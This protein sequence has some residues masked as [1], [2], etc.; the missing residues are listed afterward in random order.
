MEFSNPI[1]TSK[2]GIA[3][4]AFV[5]GTVNLSKRLAVFDRENTISLYTDDRRLK[6]LM[7]ELK[8]ATLMGLDVITEDWLWEE[9]RRERGYLHCVLKGRR[10]L[11]VYFRMKAGRTVL[12]DAW[13]REVVVLV[14][15]IDSV[16]K[17]E[18]F[19]FLTYAVEGGGDLSEF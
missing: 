8:I 18:N 19:L 17:A 9:Y 1:G 13:L 3:L 5:D 7:K 4:T 6:A 11:E 16:I 2:N 15:V 12:Q 10:K 14:E